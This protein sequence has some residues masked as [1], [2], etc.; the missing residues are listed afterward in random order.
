MRENVARKLLEN[1]EGFD[2]TVIAADTDEKKRSLI[3]DNPFERGSWRSRS[4][5]WVFGSVTVAT[6][7]ALFADRYVPLGNLSLIYLLAVFLT[8]IRCGMWPSIAASLL[9]FISYNFH[10]SLLHPVSIMNS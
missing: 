4:L 9:S 2:V 6:V 5:S 8:A 10:C 3:S 7:V 1:A